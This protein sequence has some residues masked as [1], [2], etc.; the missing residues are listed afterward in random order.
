M[1]HGG[2]HGPH[3]G[4]YSLP[5][6]SSVNQGPPGSGPGSQG[7]VNQD[8]KD[9][10][11][12]QAQSSG[13]YYSPG[14]QGNYNV[15]ISN[16]TGANYNA[17]AAAAAA[18]AATN[19][20]A[21]AAA[22]QQQS[23]MDAQAQ[24]AAEEKSAKIGEDFRSKFM[25]GLNSRTIRN[26]TPLQ[27]K[28]IDQ[29]MSR[30]TPYS[31]GLFGD[32]VQMMQDM[33]GWLSGKDQTIRKDEKGNIIYDRFGNPER[34]REG[35]ISL[36]NEMG[37]GEGSASVMESLRTSDNPLEQKT[38]FEIMGMPATSGGLESFGRNE[39]IKAAKD[40]KLTKEEQRYNNA[41]YAA[42]EA[43]RGK[44]KQD[45]GF[46]SVSGDPMIM[47]GPS[48]IAG[49]LE[50]EAA[51]ADLTPTT[52]IASLPTATGVANLTPTGLNYASMAPQFGPQ[53]PGYLNQGV[54]DPNLSQW[55]EHLSN[56]YS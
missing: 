24:A 27:Q 30:Y 40:E 31:G 25:G 11:I 42:R 43:G 55:Y 9:D 46:K 45:G 54:M 56:Y 12:G 18:Q 48:G 49:A 3:A 23:I 41:I 2:Y 22:A 10:W 5:K 33:G 15:N 38:H 6:P 8:P 35:V 50:E 32:R 29:I 34:T 44:N 37:A 51:I 28:T 7:N 39:T 17:Q 20:Q 26:L 4:G 14:G 52:G 13:Q 1:P 36:I 16:P 21:A 53:Y 47:S 19:E